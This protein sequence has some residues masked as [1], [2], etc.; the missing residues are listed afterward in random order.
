MAGTDISPAGRQRGGADAGVAAP[1]SA[2]DSQRDVIS[3]GALLPVLLRILAGLLIAVALVHWLSHMLTG[4]AGGLGSYDFSFYYDAAWALR[5]NPQANIYDPAVLQ[6][7][8]AAHHAFLGTGVYQYPPLLPILLLPL[9]LLSYGSAVKVYYLFDAVIW[10]LSALLLGDLLRFA[11]VG[12]DPTGGA[13]VRSGLRWV[14][15]PRCWLRWDAG[16]SDVTLYAYAVAIFVTLTFDPAGFALWQGQASMLILF[17][18]LLAPWLERR[19]HPLLAG[20]VL[21]L[22]T[23]VKILPAVLILYYLLRARWRVVLGAAGGLVALT[24]LM[25]A[26]VGVPGLLAMSQIPANG[27]GDSLRFQNEALSH[28][29]LWLAVEFGGGPSAVT[30]ALGYALIVLVGIA[31]VAG[32]FV[33]LRRGR[34]ADGDAPVTW[35]D[36]ETRH[37]LGYAWAL[38]TMMLVS[39]ISW[40]HH[41]IWLLPTVLICLGVAARGLVSGLR[42]SRGRVKLELFVVMAVIVAYVLNV[43]DL[44]FGYDTLN[45]LSPGPFILGHPVRP[46]F[47]LLRPV[48]ALFAWWAAGALFLRRASAAQAAIGSGVADGSQAVAAGASAPT[49]AGD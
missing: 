30:T 41:L 49:L 11:I 45:T 38:C 27:A 18:V 12:R 46:F 42:D 13:S 43:R 19:G 29:P 16:S 25:L 2:Q 14:L 22:A 35:S 28:A 6:A 24:A 33:M 44:P 36:R 1:A 34:A 26:V 15:T 39:P 23:L 47:M 4:L 48:G 5:A 37:L 17:L 9:T 31:F 21:A 10:V 40:E 7:A 32:T 20:A 3:V 8:A